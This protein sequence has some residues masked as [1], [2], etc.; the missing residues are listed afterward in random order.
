VARLSRRS[1]AATAV[2]MLT[3]GLTVFVIRHVLGG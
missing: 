3:T 1:I 2:F